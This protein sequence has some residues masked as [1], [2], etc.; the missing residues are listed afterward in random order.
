MER[1][2]DL[3]ERSWWIRLLPP[4]WFAGFDDALA[5]SGAAESWLLAGL[6][7]LG[8]GLVLW[9]AFAKLAASYESGLQT[10]GE[11]VSQ[12]RQAP[13]RRWIDA[14]LDRPPLRWWLHDPVVRASFLL[15]TAYLVRDRDVKLRVY[16]SLAP[17]LIL[18]VLFLVGRGEREGLALSGFEIAFAG[19]YL[20]LVPLLG[21]SM[22]RYSQRWQAADVF[23][24]API[25]GP[26]PLCH[27]TRRAVLCW[28]TLPLVATFA[29]LSWLLAG[30][31]AILLLLLPGMIAL[32][33]FSLVPCLGGAAIPLSQPSDEAKSAG[34]GLTMIAAV[35]V[36][37]AI[38]GLAT[39]AWWAGWFWWLVIVES[40]VA[41]GLNRVMVRS[42]AAL[43]WSSLE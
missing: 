1:L 2:G 23:H 28:L 18:P 11:T 35:M 40:I 17:F 10:L 14:L 34:R 15:T 6:A 39:M 30:D 41:V 3:G 37:M 13:S 25:A 29:V 19:G 22:L 38:S 32:P 7:V 16:P 21:V 43:R 36:S 9:L 20:G 8:T 33:T 5:G 4:A 12:R 24:C 27:G 31:S 42:I 26:A